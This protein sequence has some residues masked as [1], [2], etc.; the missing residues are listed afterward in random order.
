MTNVTDVPSDEPRQDEQAS[1]DE[2]PS[3]HDALKV[4]KIPE[5]EVRVAL[6]QSLG[7]TL[8]DEIYFAGERR[9][10]E[11]ERA[12]ELRGL[13]KGKIDLLK[14]Q[15]IP[16]FGT[17]PPEVLARI[18]SANNELLETMSLRVLSASSLDDV[19]AAP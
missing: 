8:A 3:P 17:L 10:Q 7:T 2:A 5:T 15:L 12:G 19:F 18:D 14:R 9:F 13:R 11:G 4:G 1:T 6:Q 16:R